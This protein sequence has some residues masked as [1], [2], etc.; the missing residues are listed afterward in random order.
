MSYTT[1]EAKNERTL[2]VELAQM[3]RDSEALYSLARQFKEEGE[4]EIAEEL[5]AQAKKI[6]REDWA[7]D[8]HRDNNL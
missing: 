3:T 6:D 2:E 8:E 7:Y 4:D 1:R 5:L